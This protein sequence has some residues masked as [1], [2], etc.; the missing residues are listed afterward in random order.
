LPLIGAC[1]NRLG[2]LMDDDGVSATGAVPDPATWA[3]MGIGFAGLAFAGYRRRRRPSRP[4][5]RGANPGQDE[6]VRSR[7]ALLFSQSFSGAGEP[8]LA[9]YRPAHPAPLP[10]DCREP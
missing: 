6:A 4:T 1:L 5:D 3:K 10:P 8:I 7:A 9:R 2:R